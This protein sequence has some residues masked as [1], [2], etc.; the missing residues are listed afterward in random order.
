M[1]VTGFRKSRD[2]SKEEKKNLANEWRSQAVDQEVNAIGKTE[3]EQQA[4]ASRAKSMRDNAD[5][6]D[7][8]A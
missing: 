1:P 6:L 4:A 2:A 5:K 8:S 7:P 3:A